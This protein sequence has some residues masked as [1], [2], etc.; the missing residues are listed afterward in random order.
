[1]QLRIAELE[2]LVEESAAAISFDAVR[3][4]ESDNALKAAE[5]MI[6]EMKILLAEAVGG[7]LQEAAAD[8][9]QECVT[10]TVDDAAVLQETVTMTVDSGSNPSSETKVGKLAKL[11]AD[12]AASTKA[13]R[14]GEHRTR[15]DISPRSIGDWATPKRRPDVAE[16]DPAE[17]YLSPLLSNL[18]V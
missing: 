18:Y 11:L 2:K 17:V 7:G 12:S 4:E 10:M 3:I 8:E 5:Q 13:D 14:A 9:L 1:M 16:P 6:S 15:M